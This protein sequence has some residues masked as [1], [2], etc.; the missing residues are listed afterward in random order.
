MRW[1]YVDTGAHPAEWNMQ[2]DEHLASQLLENLIA[3]TLRVYAWR[4]HAVS[5]GR[6]QSM[7]D[8]D[9][10]ALGSAGIDFVRRPTGGKAILHAHE[11]TYSVVMSC[12][13]RGLR[14][15]YRAINEGLLRGL[16]YLGIAAELT[17]AGSDFRK[18]YSEPSSVVCFSSSAKSE[19]HVNGKKLI[20]SAQRRYGSVVLQHGSLLLDN[21]H[22]HITEFLSRE[23]S[24][25]G[26]RIRLLLEDSTIDVQ[27]ILGRPVSFEE[28][29]AAIKVG[30]AGEWGTEFFVGADNSMPKIKVLMN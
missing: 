18:V 29:A 2:F 21:R 17:D 14:D 24:T 10:Q 9:L 3:P 8:F 26:E 25:E 27:S 4:P 19:I 11:L 15:V 5:I 12:A 16:R 22:R 20:G 28:A 7:S 6:H 13:D 1:A 23:L 30:C